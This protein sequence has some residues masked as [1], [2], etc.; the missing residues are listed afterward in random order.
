[1]PPQPNVDETPNKLTTVAQ[2]P[3]S[4]SC[5]PRKH[6]ALQPQNSCDHTHTPATKPASAQALPATCCIT[7]STSKGVPPSAPPSTAHPLLPALLRCA[8]RPVCRTGSSSRSR[9]GG[10][11]AAASSRGHRGRCD[12]CALQAKA[13]GEGLTNS[14][15][16]MHACR[17]LRLTNTPPTNKNK[18]P[19]KPPQPHLCAAL[20]GQHVNDAVDEALLARRVPA[21]EALTRL[22]QSGIDRGEGAANTRKQTTGHP[23]TVSGCWHNSLNSNPSVASPALFDVSARPGWHVSTQTWKP[24]VPA[25]PQVPTPLAF[26]VSHQPAGSCSP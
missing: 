24:N 23:E 3:R 10:S 11:P 9:C 5:E 17:Y 13:A 25:V 8:A 14:S 12:A 26:C 6:T 20:V 19:N 21:P 22:W 16:C 7:S 2:Y 4:Q 15:A 1:M 18:T